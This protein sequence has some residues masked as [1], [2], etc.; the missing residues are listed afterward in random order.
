MHLSRCT[1]C[2][3]LDSVARDG[4]SREMEV[5]S[6]PIPV[7]D[8]EKILNRLEFANRRGPTIRAS[9]APGGFSRVQV[10]I[11]TVFTHALSLPRNDGGITVLNCLTTTARFMSFVNSTSHADCFLV[12]L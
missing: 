4:R 12:K 5:Q 7:V 9:Q 2:I 6:A 11:C 3:C 8:A 10:N 1:P